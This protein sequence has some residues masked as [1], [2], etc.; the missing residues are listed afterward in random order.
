MRVAALQFDV[1]ATDYAANLERA[2]AGIE[3]AAGAGIELVALPE[4]W[5]TS[6]VPA[7]G[8]AEREATEQALAELAARSA[9][10]GLVIVGSA[11]H[12]PERDALPTNRLHLFDQGQ[13]KLVHDKVH[14]FTPTA[15]DQSFAAGERASLATTT[16][17]GRIAG[18]VCY[19]LRFPELCRATFRSGAE[20]LVVCAQW[21]APRAAHWK[22]LVVGRAV[23]NQCFM[24]A[25]NR[26]GTSLIGRR[27]LELE[28]SGNSLIVS[29]HGE[30]LAEGRPD[31]E[32][33]SA[34][35]DL[36]QARELRVRVPVAKDDRPD[37]HAAWLR[38]ALEQSR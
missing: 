15:E 34:D 1:S 33:V 23:E 29:P 38:A 18:L 37:L 6:F 3:R 32:I 22:A 10:T 11:F 13:L 36:D 17:R 4:M 35:I 5:P 25:C 2:R 28:F 30:L 27:Q 19:D 16:S 7:A 20:L 12:W 31:Q 24:L 21:P 9:E 8:A 26:T 14:L